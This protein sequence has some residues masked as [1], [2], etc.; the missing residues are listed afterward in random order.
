[1]TSPASPLQASSTTTSPSVSSFFPDVRA[2]CLCT[3]STSDRPT[4]ATLPR[5]ELNP[6]RHHLLHTH[7]ASHG[8]PNATAKQDH[9]SL[10]P[11]L[12]SPPKRASVRDTGTSYALLKLTSPKRPQAHYSA[13]T[14]TRLGTQN[15]LSSEGLAGSS[16]LE[17]NWTL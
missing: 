3:G 5:V 10:H 11:S 6:L 17:E 13:T 2:L 8:A 4:A 14:V 12:P 7:T 15:V 16:V 1:M 9:A